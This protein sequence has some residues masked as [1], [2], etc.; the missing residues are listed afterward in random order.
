MIYLIMMFLPQRLKYG[1]QIVIYLS[2]NKLSRP[3]PAHKIANQ[4]N[5]PKE[6]AAKILQEL[7]GNGILKSQ[8]GKNG[9]FNL[10]VNPSEIKIEKVFLALGFVTNFNECVFE[11]KS[12][13]EKE[14]CSFCNGW[15]MFINDFNFMIRNYSL[16]KIYEQSSYHVNG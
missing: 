13:C 7:A 15:R 5:I 12:V 1:M 9:G 3:I 16:D 10:C 8:K 2:K 6:F 4:L 11:S 14:K